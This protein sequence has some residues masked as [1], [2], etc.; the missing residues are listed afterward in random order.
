MI[1]G[2]IEYV[3]PAF[4]T[5]RVFIGRSKGK[6]P[7][8]LKSGRIADACI[9]IYGLISQRKHERELCNKKKMENYIGSNN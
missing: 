6:N 8:V 7:R 5:T 9:W 3:N 1:Q 4:T 2:V